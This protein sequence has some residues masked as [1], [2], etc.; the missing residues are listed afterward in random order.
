MYG[1][2]SLGYYHFLLLDEKDKKKIVAI[3][4]EFSRISGHTPFYFSWTLP[5]KMFLKIKKIVITNSLNYLGV[6]TWQ[7]LSGWTD[8]KSANLKWFKKVSIFPG[9]TCENKSFRDMND[10][11]KKLRSTSKNNSRDNTVPRVGLGR[12]DT[13]KIERVGKGVG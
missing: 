7:K 2:Y 4:M 9:N 13:I 11:N 6:K 1:F 12:L 8:N 5:L 3:I 10:C